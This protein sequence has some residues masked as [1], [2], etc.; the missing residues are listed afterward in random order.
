MNKRSFLI[1]FALVVLAAPVVNA[2]KVRNVIFMI[3]DGM[4]LS[5]TQ[6]AMMTSTTPLAVER[7][8]Y[9]GLIQTHS[10]NNRVTD[11]AAAG[12]ALSTGYKTNNGAVGLDTEGA[13]VQNL[14]EFANRQGKSTGVVVTVDITHATPAAFLAH[15]PKRSMTEE[16]AADIV[17]SGVDVFIGGGQDRFEKRKDGQNLSIALQAKG[18]EVVYTGD[19]M[20]NVRGGKLA[21][22]LAPEHMPSIK[23]GRDPN[24]LAEATSQ[25]LDILSQN[26]KGFFLMVEG[27]Q[28]DWA[29]HSN[30]GASAALEAVD[31]WQA[32]GRAFDFADKHPGTLVIVT[33]DHETGGMTL[34]SGNADFL[35]ADQ[36][37]DVKFSTGGHSASMVPVYTYGAGASNF[38]TVMDNT[39][40]PKKVMKLMK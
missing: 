3:G 28:I 1:V 31:F 33:A 26:K 32:V 36:G 20:R 35:L 25:A 7:A 29:C 23:D 12:T 40:L 8:Q 2:Q 22:M 18:Y 5:Q 11:S 24:Y 17:D 37:V 15:Q 14:T 38:T 4:G 27:S 34:P 13:K 39:D 6:V 9:V 30:D 19:D 16:I 10:A 21:A